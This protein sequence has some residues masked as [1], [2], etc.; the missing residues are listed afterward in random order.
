V[1]EQLCLDGWAATLIV[2]E[3]DALPAEL[4]DQTGWTPPEF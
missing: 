4:L 2:V 3:Q 1:A